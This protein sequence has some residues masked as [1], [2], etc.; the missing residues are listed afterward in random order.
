MPRLITR[1]VLS[2][3]DVAADDTVEIAPTND[4]AKGDTTFVDT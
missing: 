2:T 1:F 4:K 3:I